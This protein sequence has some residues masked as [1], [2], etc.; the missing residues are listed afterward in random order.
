MADILWRTKILRGENQRKFTH[1]TV[2]AFAAF[3]PWLISWQSIQLIAL[4]MTVVVL[5]NRPFQILHIRG[6]SKKDRETYGDVLLAPAILMCALITTNKIF[7]ALAV[8]NM[9]LAD[10]IAA[11]VGINF[12]RHWRYKVFHQAKT[13]IGSMAFWFVSLCIFAVGLLFLHDSLNFIQYT[14][15]LLALPPVLMVV[16][17]VAGLGLDNIF[18]PLAALIA[19]QIL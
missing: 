17:N 18:V 9:A 4:A 8:L 14:V 12:G 3:W 1:I 2:G 11:I 16:E 15:L 10:G 13:V 6:I 7:F 5:I 19:L